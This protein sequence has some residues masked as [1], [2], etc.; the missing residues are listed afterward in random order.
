M[1][2]AFFAFILVRGNSSGQTRAAGL[3]LNAESLRRDAADKLSKETLAIDNLIE[4]AASGDALPVNQTRATIAQANSD[5]SS[6]QSELSQRAAALDKAAKLN[7]NSNFKHY[8]ALLKSDNDKL[9]QAIAAGQQITALL[10][11]QLYSLAGWDQAQAQKT[12]A[13]VHARESSMDK[14][15]GDAEALHNQAA[16]L[17]QDHP[18][19]FD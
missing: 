12:V 6:A 14:I 5:L 3:S 1:G 9:E 8:L 17:K 2:A 10:Q 19:D 13:Q 7:V 4:G 18:D 11:N 15:L 16:Q